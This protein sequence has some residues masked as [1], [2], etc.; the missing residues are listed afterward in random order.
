MRPILRV[1]LFALTAAPVSA[2]EPPPR[3]LL[4]V[5][6]RIKP[7]GEGAY[8]R[9]E[10]NMARTCARLKCPH[11]YLALESVRGPKEV[12]WLNAFASRA[13]S[14]RVD[15]AYRSDEALVEELRKNAQQKEPLTYKPVTIW[16]HYRADLST[17]CSWKVAGAR[18]FVVIISPIRMRKAG[19]CVFESTSAARIVIMPVVNESDAKEWATLGGS[20]SRIFAVQPRWSM[21]ANA[22][23]AADS[24]FWRDSPAVQSQRRGSPP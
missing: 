23:V 14:A 21:P 19:R 22:W 24:G 2:Q 20:R 12:W 6:E 13:D 11:P 16:T 17:S 7:N 3:F 9:I 8:D 18:Y 4:I 15:R 1:I 10:Q 5:Q